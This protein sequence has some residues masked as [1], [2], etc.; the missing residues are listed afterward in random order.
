MFYVI[1]VFV[2]LSPVGGI[3]LKYRLGKRGL[4]RGFYEEYMYLFITTVFWSGIGWHLATA[5]LHHLFSRPIVWGAT[6]KEVEN[7]NFFHELKLVWQRY[8]WLYITMVFVLAAMAAEM[9][10][11]QLGA[12]KYA[13]DFR[14]IFPTLW[15]ITCHLLAPILLNPTLMKVQC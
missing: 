12:T 7:T 5:I 10:L 15:G 4:L 14:F 1:A 11:P 9:F 2:G 8:R 6:V 3:I 13:W